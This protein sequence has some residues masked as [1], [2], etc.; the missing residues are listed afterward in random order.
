MSSS[1][2]TPES[3][4][5][6]KAEALADAASG[7]LAD[8]RGVA[9]Y[10][11][12]WFI[13]CRFTQAGESV[14]SLKNQFHEL[15]YMYYQLA[16]FTS[17]ESPEQDRLALDIVRILGRGEPW[18]EMPFFASDM[19]ELWKESFAVLSSTH[20]VNVASFM[21]KLVAAKVAFDQLSGIAL[22]LLHDTLEEERA[23]GSTEE[24]DSDEEDAKRHLDQLTIAQMLPCLHRWIKDTDHTLVELS[25]CS[26][27]DVSSTAA[28]GQAGG[29]LLHQWLL[30]TR[31]LS[32]AGF[33]PW[34]FMFWIKRL[35]QIREAAR[36]ADDEALEECARHAAEMMVTRVAERQSTY[37]INAYE[38]GGEVL[39]SDE[40]LAC[41]KDFVV[42]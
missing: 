35:L 39:Q 5:T 22:T 7:E 24:A 4:A 2:S 29:P 20:R 37:I 42:S 11:R 28:L 16:R 32:S 26:G 21:A 10:N 13:T 23:L 17:S 6:A 1:V 15:W 19:L 9:F 38:N 8:L 12:T 36:A 25:N 41:L 3:L 14:E 34:R 18:T 27:N 33:S 30:E 31:S 40:H